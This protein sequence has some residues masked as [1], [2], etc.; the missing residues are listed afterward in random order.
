MGVELQ[1]SLGDQLG[2]KGSVPLE[3]AVAGS[4]VGLGCRLFDAGNRN[5]ILG[6]GHRIG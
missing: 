6:G 3:K 2:R 4:R 5:G 1:G